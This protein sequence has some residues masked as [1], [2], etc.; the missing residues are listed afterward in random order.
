MKRRD[1]ARLG[2]MTAFATS[3]LSNGG[4]F[5]RDAAISRNR[6]LGLL[7][8][9][10]V[11]DALGGPL[12]FS[13]ASADEKKLID[14][15]SW[16]EDRQISNADL[17]RCAE[18]LPLHGYEDLRPNSAPYGPWRERAP[19]GTLTDD[20]RHKIVLMDAIREAHKRGLEITPEDIAHS[21]LNFQP[22]ATHG[23]ESNLMVLNEEGFREYRYAARWLLG[24]RVLQR[25]RPLS[26]LWA[27]VN[28][29]SG[30][31]M[32]PPLAVR[33]AGDPD[34]AYRTTYELDFIDAAIARDITSSFVAGLASLLS[35][36]MDGSPSQ[37]RWTTFLAGM[38]DTDPF[39]YRDVPFAGRQLHRWLSKSEEFVERAAGKPKR[40]Y[41]LLESEGQPAFWWDAHFTLLVPLCM[42]RFCDYNPLAALHL[43]LDFGHDTDSYAQVLGCM[44][45]AVHGKDVFP[46][47]MLDAVSQS[48]K[49][50]YGE[51]V[52]EWYETLTA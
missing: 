13:R 49:S 48:L 30:Q 50:D 42:I 9:G 15:R 21:F 51:S 11:G 34:Q 12:E 40:L 10:L 45:G 20:S 8:G 1:I 2:L 37:Q 43:T 52:S 17:E 33:F 7:Y 16:P 23:D 39:R 32:F 3:S 29:C 24:D 31:M 44:I 41:E 47:D 6:S 26:R 14:A 27:G 5:A 38:R 18:S 25:A 19:A 22:V 4:A 28:N 36:D 46:L 35:V